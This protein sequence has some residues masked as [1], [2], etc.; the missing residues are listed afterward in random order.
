MGQREDLLKVLKVN[1]EVYNLLKDAKSITIPTSREELIEI[2]LNGDLNN[3]QVE[4]AY[5]VPGKG[6]VVEV[7]L[8]KAKN[9]LVIN[10]P[11]VYMRRRDPNAAVVG[12]DKIT[13]KAR[14][15]ER[16]G[17]DFSEVRKETFEWL[18]KQ[19]LIVVPFITIKPIDGG[20][21]SIYIGPKNTA[22]FALTFIDFQNFVNLDEMRESYK[23]FIF[24]FVAPVFRHTHFDGKQVVVHNRL[25]DRYEI[26]PYNLYP[27][28]SS[29]KGIYGALLEIGERE[30]WVTL[31]AAAVKVRTHYGN[32]SVFMH[33][34]ASGGGKSEMNEPIHYTEDGRILVGEN[35]KT[36]E[37]I[38]IDIPQP[39][40][41]VP[42]SDDMTLAHKKIQKN[43]GRLTI[44]DAEQ[45][46]FIRMDHIRRYGTDPYLERMCIHPKKPLIFVNLYTVPD[47]T[48]LPWEHIED[49]PGKPCPNPRVVLPK[50]QL[51]DYV[52]EPIE[53]DFRSFGIRT[54][55]TTKEN[56]NY[57]IIGF[58]HV[59]PPAVAWL[60]RLV[61]PRGFNNPSIVAEEGLKSEG[62]GSYGPFLI[63]DE[64]KQ[65][66]LLL[67]QFINY[68]DTK[69][70][71]VPNQY[72]GA[73]KVSFMPQWIT[74]E[75]LARR[76][77]AWFEKDELKPTKGSIL[78]YIPKMV[79]VEGFIIPEFLFDV[80]LQE[81]VG[82]EVYFEGLE[83]LERFFAKELKRF[84]NPRLS[85][86][87]RRI[88]ECFMDKGTVEEFESIIPSE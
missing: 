10:Y 52:K 35:I 46:W 38:F 55:P 7:V 50:D 8:T 12:D 63:G 43:K 87:G 86:T 13:T 88:I 81:E 47:A 21:P 48:V 3:K 85:E 75:Y 58:F 77:R 23:P 39:S 73:W 72:I 79:E 44:Y 62:I 36:N 67:E 51:D 78:G 34:G 45:A 59:L 70:I 74:R 40:K 82:E 61:A 26:F 41:L 22:G 84:N 18:K 24:V 42:I 33:E 11:E 65:A 56:P 19:D 4:I 54:P 14:F 30:G 69:Y 20:Y 66:D 57:G 15:K 29:K 5:D 1:E 76:G 28:P 60:W 25:D 37:K 17:R 83:Q 64:I 32:V 80:G 71:L 2:A 9:G 31:H 27:G 16:F 6:K 68:K 53:V 49:E